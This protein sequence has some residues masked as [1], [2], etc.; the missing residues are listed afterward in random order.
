MFRVP[1]FG[2]RAPFREME[3]LQR[4]MNRLF[5]ETMSPGRGRVA[6]GYPAMNI[7]ANEEG[8]IVTAEL[9]GVNPEDI[10][11]AVDGD[12]LTLTGVRHPEALKEGETYHRR[13]RGA[14]KFNRVFQ[15]P[16]QV[17]MEAVEATFANGVLH[18]TLPRAEE[19]KPRKIE[20]KTG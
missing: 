14:G 1:Y 8:V 3:R 6:A 13:E 9:P 15:L 18:I 5:T 11:I 7:W 20:V 4:E 2:Y 16:F 10:D 17:E 12:T 19:D